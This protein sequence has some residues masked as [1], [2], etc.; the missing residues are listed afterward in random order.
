MVDIVLTGDGRSVTARITRRDGAPARLAALSAV[1]EDG[2]RSKVGA[3]ENAGERLGHDYVVREM[4]QVP[5]WLGATQDLHFAPRLATDPE[6]PRAINLV[7]TDA[8]S[9]RPVQAMRFGC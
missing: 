6:H 7:V 5:P 8:T 4:L 2:H 3:G 9:G 1:T